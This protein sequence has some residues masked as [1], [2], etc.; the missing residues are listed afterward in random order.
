MSVAIAYGD[1]QSMRI[2]PSQSSG[3]KRKAGSTVSFTTSDAILYRST[4]GPSSGRLR[5]RADRRRS[6]RRRRGRVHID[7]G[8]RGRSRRSGVIVQMRGRRRR[9]RAY[10]DSRD[11]VPAHRRAAHLRALDPR[12]HIAVGRAAVRRVVLEPAVLGRIVRRRDDDP[13]RL[14]GRAAA[15][16]RE[17][18]MRDRPASACSPSSVV[19]EDLDVVG[20]QHFEGVRNAGSERACVSMPMIQRPRRSRARCDTGRSPG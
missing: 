8:V 3:M 14:P 5:R 17:D 12:R 7:H 18:R 19:D 16:V 13:I 1:E 6:S 2:L 11:A 9:A 20:R 15:V 10:G 4:M